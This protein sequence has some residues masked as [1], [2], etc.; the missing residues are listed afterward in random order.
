MLAAFLD[1]HRHLMEQGI[2]A[3]TSLAELPQACDNGWIPSPELFGT[4][5]SAL[6]IPAQ[7]ELTAQ[8][9][10]EFPRFRSIRAHLSERQ[11]SLLAHHSSFSTPLRVPGHPVDEL[12]SQFTPQRTIWHSTMES[13]NLGIFEQQPI[14]LVAAADKFLH[15]LP[16]D[17]PP[18]CDRCHHL[19][20]HPG[21]TTHMATCRHRS[22]LWTDAHEKCNAVLSTL[23]K[24]SGVRCRVH[25]QGVPG[26]RQ[27]VSQHGPEDHH[28]GDFELP[29][30]MATGGGWHGLILDFSM[31]HVFDNDGIPDLARS[32]LQAAAQ[33]KIRGHRNAYAQHVPPKAFLPIIASTDGLLQDDALRFLWWLADRSA[34]KETAA[35]D[36]LSA[37][38]DVSGDPTCKRIR[39]RIF[40]QLKASLSYAAIIAG[41]S[42]LVGPESQQQRA[43]CFCTLLD[44][45]AR[46][47][48]KE[49]LYRAF[50]EVQRIKR[51]MRNKDLSFN[52]SLKSL[53][54][55]KGLASKAFQSCGDSG[56]IPMVSQQ[57][58]FE[59]GLR[60]DGI[61]QEHNISEKFKIQMCYDKGRM[62]G[63]ILVEKR[64]DCN[65]AM[66]FS[67]DP[68][69]VKMVRNQS[70]P[71]EFSFNLQG[72]ELH[73]LVYNMRY[74]GQCRYELPFKVTTPGKYFVNLVWWRENYNG[75]T[76][77]SNGW[78]PAHFDL[79]LGLDVFIHLGEPGDDMKETREALQRNRN[80]SDLPLCD[81]RDKNYT[82]MDGRWLYM[83]DD[84][85]NIFYSP[86]PQQV[87]LISGGAS[88]YTWVNLEKYYWY[89]SRCKLRHFE[90]KQ[91][92]NCI[93]SKTIRMQGD[94]HLRTIANALSDLACGVRSGGFDSGC[95][96]ACKQ[97]DL[98]RNCYRKDGLG[99]A[100]DF[101]AD[102]GAAL[103]VINLGQHF[104]DGERKMK[105]AQYKQ[106]IDAGVDKMSK[107]S[108]DA[109]RTMIWH[110]TNAVMFRKDSWIVGYG[111]QRTNI[112]IAMYNRYATAK[113]KELGITVLPTFS[114][115]LALAQN[116]DEA[117]Y[118]LKYLQ[119]SSVQ[120]LLNFFC[121]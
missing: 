50:A 73:S 74:L 46:K 87:R 113:M 110:E 76:E 51:P 6:F 44:S 115:S 72:P 117:H 2:S 40:R 30:L 34:N 21:G 27:N 4:S 90:G 19:L 80:A 79:P 57:A 20:R 14:S 43:A 84:V 116:P 11:R 18:H 32:K 105:F 5:G 121:Q 102:Q 91:A 28:V 29:Q 100:P 77:L 92:L 69:Y 17:L 97:A 93:A 63:K 78:L 33:R 31:S 112:R 59:S 118:P 103:N 37:S 35:L 12:L 49:Q 3:Y 47:K 85:E 99:H 52:N 108:P 107:L 61:K 23:I 119:H 38:Q 16:V 88:M 7:R 82:Y 1:T 66:E 104:C 53:L 48:I 109:R 65:E 39:S 96:S 41:A 120:Y 70:G 25:V 26:T 83:Y 106:S 75:A 45:E 8:F 10:S 67:G 98:S 54:R 9:L 81:M 56:W 13:T 60:L 15:G 22:Q 95:A 114:A 89:P 86:A 101:F 42:R 36:G 62:S 111:D 94:S 24:D 58:S 64:F 55:L 68:Q 71:D